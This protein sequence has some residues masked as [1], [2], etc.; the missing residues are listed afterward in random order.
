MTGRAI[1]DFS[2]QL[3]VLLDQG[4]DLQQPF[5]LRLRQLQGGRCRVVRMG[6]GR[7]GQG[8][9]AE[10]GEPQLRSG[11]SVADAAA[12]AAGSGAEALL[13]NCSRPEVMGKAVRVARDVLRE[14]QSDLEVGVYANAFE[15]REED[16]A[17]NE[18][19]HGTREDLTAT[20]YSRFACDWA[21]AGATLIGGCCGIGARHI[22]D[23]AA[24]LGR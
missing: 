11:E 7:A 13:F 9:G 14:R 21:E 1:I 5:H 4:V 6:E 18:T 22:H 10:D 17:A 20:A 16:G 24:A 3:V 15:E 19:L 8:E 2:E 23:L 12:W